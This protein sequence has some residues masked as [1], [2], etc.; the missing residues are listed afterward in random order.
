VLQPQEHLNQSTS[1][2]IAPPK[3]FGSNP[4]V[5]VAAN[6]GVNPPHFKDGNAESL[7][8]IESSVPLP[9]QSK[10]V[11]D[12]PSLNSSYTEALSLEQPAALRSVKSAEAVSN[13]SALRITTSD[14]DS[15]Y[16]ST[17]ENLEE[18]RR[19]EEEYQKSLQRAKKVY[20]SRM[21]NLQ[22]SLNERE[23]QHLQNLMKHEK[24]RAEF[25]K[26]VKLAEAEQAKRLQE[27]EAKCRQQKAELL[28]SK[29]KSNGLKRSS[30]SIV[31]MEAE[32]AN[33]T[34]KTSISCADIGSIT[35]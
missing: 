33:P 22:R 4:H 13:L 17:E 28:K 8:G 6:G 1:P 15:S 9:K 32:P 30:S 11:A 25:E 20:D 5:T 19:I 2:Q 31:G 23:A 3:Q 24:E 35:R 14:D 29:P 26:K 16:V 21:E 18:L 27:L 34:T 7:L 10:T 12:F